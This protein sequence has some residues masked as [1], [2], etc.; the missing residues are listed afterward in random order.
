MEDFYVS[1][2]IHRRML[3]DDVRNQAYRQALF[4]TIKP[5]H[6]VLDVGAGTGILSLFAAQAGARRVYAVE[7][8]LMAQLTRRLIS[9]NGYQDRIQ[10][11]A[12]DIKTA[13]LPEKVDVIVSEWLG[14]FGVDENM[15]P[16]VLLARDRWLKPGGI[17]LP[18]IVSA[19]MVPIWHKELDEA[20]TYWRDHT[21]GLDLSLIAEPTANEMTW[22][23]HPIKKEDFLAEPQIMWTTDTARTSVAQAQ[24]PFRSALKFSATRAAKV[25]ALA[26][27]FKAEFGQ[28]ITLTNAPEESPTHWKQYVIPLYRSI[29]VTPGTNIAVEF[30]CIPA[31]TNSFCFNAWSVRIGQG[32]WE[33]HDTRKS[34]LR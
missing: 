25:N 29:E 1:L 19:V 27:W 3:R 33:H 8:T 10:V 4:A 24:L 21:Y 11:I 26:S 7:R 2:D 12:A 32:P 20:M 34:Y 13:Y 17:M 23:E 22:P 6:V 28:G 15:L 30:T 31:G 5:N 14:T 16:P 18:K 9:I